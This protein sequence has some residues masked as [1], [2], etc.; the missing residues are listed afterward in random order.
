PQAAAVLRLYSN[1]RLEPYYGAVRPS[2][3]Q[4]VFF[5]HWCSTIQCGQRMRAVNGGVRSNDW[6]SVSML[7]GIGFLVIGQIVKTVPMRA[8]PCTPGK[9]I[10][11]RRAN[12]QI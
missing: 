4:A 9:L 10:R 7:V 3:T 1:R 6:R 11:R 2:E 5:D 12:Y 8:L